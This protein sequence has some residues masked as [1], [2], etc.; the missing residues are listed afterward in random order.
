MRT[1]GD[2]KEERGETTLGEIIII[3]VTTTHHSM[4]VWGDRVRSLFLSCSTT[5]RSEPRGLDPSAPSQ[6]SSQACRSFPS[7]SISVLAGV[8]LVKAVGSRDSAR[9]PSLV[10]RSSRAA[11]LAGNGN[12]CPEM[13]ADARGL[14]AGQAA[15]PASF[16][17][18]LAS[19]DSNLSL[20][21][22]G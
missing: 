5:G 16:P 4:C 20:Q 11:F 6:N 8:W 3:L 21:F 13:M 12:S 17:H 9:R 14:C 1:E 18:S 15:S 19:L 22:T 7:V 2:G 10:L